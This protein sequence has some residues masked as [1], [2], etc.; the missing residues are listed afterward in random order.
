MT[1]ALVNGELFLELPDDKE[2][3]QELK[4]THAFNR[5]VVKKA[6]EVR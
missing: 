4:L 3:L 6:K 1:G 2:F 5:L